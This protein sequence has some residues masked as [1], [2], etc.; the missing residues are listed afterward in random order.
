M[1][2]TSPRT[3]LPSLP[4]ILDGNLDLWEPQQLKYLD[5]N[6]SWPSLVNEPISYVVAYREI[7]FVEAYHFEDTGALIESSN[8]VDFNIS[9]GKFYYKGTEIDLSKDFQLME[10]ELIILKART[11]GYYVWTRINDFGDF[12]I[13]NGKLTNRKSM[14][15][16]DETFIS[17]WPKNRDYSLTSSI[18]DKVFSSAAIPVS[19]FLKT[20][21][22]RPLTY[23]EYTLTDEERL[24]LEESNSFLDY[25][26]S[27]PYNS[28]DGQVVTI[29]QEFERLK[30][31]VLW[32]NVFYWCNL[33]FKKRHY[34]EEA[35][36]DV[37]WAGIREIIF[38]R[39]DSTPDPSNP[40][41]NIAYIWVEAS[42]VNRYLSFFCDSAGSYNQNRVT[43]SFNGTTRSTDYSGH[44]GIYS[45]ASGWLE[46]KQAYPNAI[47]TGLRQVSTH[48]HKLRSYEYGHY[49][50]LVSSFG[51]LRTMPLLDYPSKRIPAFKTIKNYTQ[52]IDYNIDTKSITPTGRVKSWGTKLLPVKKFNKHAEESV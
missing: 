8:T 39:V 5:G 43:I 52:E 31:F 34:T 19:G 42:S 33:S 47:L 50:Q 15:G 23:P 51:Q 2:E 10:D 32:N 7:P 12:K 48:R 20:T 29:A 35:I 25:K 46:I 44:T 1:I 40:E 6:N 3:P 38:S 22:D 18:E 26:D 27:F 13:N 11:P 17:L 9:L 14:A 21:E 45:S 16:T 24:I 30:A 49:D 41:V 37:P 36:P 28:S 4:D